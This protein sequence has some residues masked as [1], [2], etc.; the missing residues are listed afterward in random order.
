[1]DIERS[2]A[3]TIDDRPHPDMSGRI[4][5]LNLQHASNYVSLMLPGENDFDLVDVAGRLIEALT[6]VRVGAQIRLESLP[7]AAR[8]RGCAVR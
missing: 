2:T 4:V 6:R 3:I 8:R 5:H 1:M 7:S